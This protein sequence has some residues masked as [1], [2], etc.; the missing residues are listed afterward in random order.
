MWKDRSLTI[1]PVTVQVAVSGSYSSAVVVRSVPSLPPATSTRPSGS[2]V[3]VCPARASVI[4]AVAV[5][6]P[7]LGS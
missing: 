2:R 3:A 7:V 5:H 4:G 1:G 6:A